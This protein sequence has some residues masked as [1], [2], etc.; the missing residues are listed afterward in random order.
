MVARNIPL[1]LGAHMPVSVRSGLYQGAFAKQK[2][3][4]RTPHHPGAPPVL[5]SLMWSAEGL[6]SWRNWP[7][8]WPLPPTN[9]PQVIPKAM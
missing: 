6:P 1:A 8:R 9:P 2:S 5:G 3:G 7:F 4:P